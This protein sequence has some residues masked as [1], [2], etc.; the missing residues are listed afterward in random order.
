MREFSPMAARIFT[1]PGGILLDP[2]S[3]QTML[4]RPFTA[5]ERSNAETIT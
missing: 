1:N 2:A 5:Q 4:S 3:S